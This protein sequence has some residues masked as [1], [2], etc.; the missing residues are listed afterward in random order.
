MQSMSAIIDL[1]CPMAPA[2]SN[3]AGQDLPGGASS[4]AATATDGVIGAALL[5]VTAFRLRDEHGLIEAL[6]HLANAVAR[7]EAAQE[8]V[9]A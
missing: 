4:P 3:E 7:L 2:N 8:A 1:S 6:R 9:E 5:A